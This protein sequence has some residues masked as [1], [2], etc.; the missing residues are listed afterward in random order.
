MISPPDG[1]WTQVVQT[2]DATA[3]ITYAIYFKYATASGASYT[4]SK[5]INSG[6]LFG[7]VIAAWR[8]TD[9]SN[10]LD[11]TPG[12]ATATASS[13][14]VSFPAYDPTETDSHI[15]YTAFYSDDQ[16]TFAAAMSSDT[17]PDCTTRVDQ[18]TPT[19][20]DFSIAITSGDTTD[21]S[22]IA[23]RTWAS[24]STVDASN[25]GYVFALRTPAYGNNNGA[26]IMGTNF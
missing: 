19:A 21:G 3:S 22:P 23:S 1:T 4:F 18:E 8:N 15:V 6:T 25:V 11:P 10:P 16:T 20:T 7:G 14:A 5:D 2:Q 13:D 17:N 26:L 24:N 9:T 12:G